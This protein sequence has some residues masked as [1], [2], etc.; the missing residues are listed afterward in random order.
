MEK[1]KIGIEL[2]DTDI[3]K[4]IEEWEYHQI[5]NFLQLYEQ[6]WNKLAIILVKDA[7]FILNSLINLWENKSEFN[8]KL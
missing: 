7:E 2:P 1:N 5:K 8:K 6:S 3:N 4:F